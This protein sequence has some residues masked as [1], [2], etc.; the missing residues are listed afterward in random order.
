MGAERRTR[1]TDKNTFQNFLMGICNKRI[2]EGLFIEVTIQ[3]IYFPEDLLECNFLEWTSDNM[4]TN[5]AF[6][7]SVRFAT[8]TAPAAPAPAAAVPAVQPLTAQVITAA[9]SA[10]LAATPAPTAHGN[11]VLDRFCP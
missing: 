3:G 6:P 5:R 9:V 10:A 2:Y 7:P 11:S 8:G 1:L 4:K